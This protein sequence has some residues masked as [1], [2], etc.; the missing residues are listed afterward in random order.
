MELKDIKPENFFKK[1]T[2]DSDPSPAGKLK[3]PNE[4][5]LLCAILLKLEDTINKK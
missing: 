5:F 3:I 2:F 1:I 4:Y